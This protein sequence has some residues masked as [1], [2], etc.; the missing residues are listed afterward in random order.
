MLKVSL[1]CNLLNL[2]F[3]IIA[4]DKAVEAAYEAEKLRR[5]YIRKRARQQKR[6]ED[7]K[8]YGGRCPCCGRSIDDCIWDD[9]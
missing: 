9:W 7:K 1:E 8:K 6:A 2:Q 3:L 4:K 5:K